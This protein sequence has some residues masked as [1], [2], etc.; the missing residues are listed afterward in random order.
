MADKQ[1]IDVSEFEKRRDQVHQDENGAQ[2]NLAKSFEHTTVY[3][4][5][6]ND[7]VFKV[8]LSSDVRTKILYC[9]FFVQFVRN[10][11]G[12]PKEDCEFYV[13]IVLLAT[14]YRRLI[15]SGVLSYI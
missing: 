13:C 1:T 3:R 8:N 6:D 4:R 2:W 9:T 11:V 7:S 15:P 5:A 12:I 10:M 14:R